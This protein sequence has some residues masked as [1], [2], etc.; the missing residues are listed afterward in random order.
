MAVLIVNDT[1]DVNA[2]G[3]S[4]SLAEPS[5]LA[6]GDLLLAM[7]FNAGVT[8]S[9]A[10]PGNITG[11]ASDFDELSATDGYGVRITHR[12]A[13]G[14]EG[15]TYA[16]TVSGDTVYSG[17][18]MLRVIGADPSA[19]VAAA[20]ANYGSGTT[21]TLPS[22]AATDGPVLAVANVAAASPIT[23]TPSGW[24]QYALYDSNTT[25]I[26]YRFIGDG[27]SS[28]TGTCTLTSSAP[29]VAQVALV[30]PNLTYPPVG[31]VVTEIG[32]SLGSNN[33]QPTFA[34][35]QHAGASGDLCLYLVGHDNPGA[36][37]ITASPGWT[38]LDLTVQ[39]S[40]V[41]KAA[42]VARVL[43]GA[44]GTGN[45]TCSIS[46]TTQDYAVIGVVIP[47]GMH[48]VT[49]VST[50]ITRGTPSTAGSGNTDPP[51]VT[52]TSGDYTV[53]TGC[54]ADA[55][56]G[57]SIT[58]IPSDYGFLLSTKSANSTSSVMVGLAARNV[59]GT[60]EN[61]GAWAHNSQENI[62]FTFAVPA[63]APPVDPPDAPTEVQPEDAFGY[64]STVV[65]NWTAPVDDGGATITGY[66]IR[67]S[68]DDGASWSTH[69]A[70]TGDDDETFT[71][72]TGLTDG[73]RYLFEVAAINSEGVGATAVSEW[74]CTPIAATAA[75][76]PP[77]VSPVS[78]SFDHLDRHDKRALV[79]MDGEVTRNWT[80]DGVVIYYLDSGIRDTHEQFTGRVDGVSLV[81]GEAWDDDAAPHGTLIASVGSGNTLGIASEAQTHM[82]KV[83]HEFDLDG[84]AWLEWAIDGLQWIVDNHETEYPGQ[85]AVVEYSSAWGIDLTGGGIV[86]ERAA[87]AALIADLADMGIPFIQI[88]HNSDFPVDEVLHL[89]P[90]PG[91][92][93]VGGLDDDD[94]VF[95]QT[96]LTGL[97]IDIW[98]QA[99]TIDH[100]SASSDTGY[101]SA[102]EGT[103]FAGPLV[104]G[105]AAL[106]L[107]ANPTLTARQVCDVL[108]ASSTK[109]TIVSPPSGHYD[110]I[111]YT[112]PDVPPADVSV[113]VT[114][115]T[116]AA[117]AG[118][119]TPTVSLGVSI[120]ASVVAAVCSVLSP[121]VTASTPATS[122]P[123]T[124]QAVSN[125]PPPA[126]TATSSASATPSTVTAPATVQAP[127]VA[128]GTGQTVT[129]DV[130]AVAANV[131]SPTVSATSSTTAIPA[132]VTAT[133]TVPAPTIT[134]TSSA[135]ATPATVVTASTAVPAPSISAGG[136]ATATPATV[137]VTATVPA[138]TVSAAVSATAT[139]S[140]ITAA[141]TVPA[142]SVS[143]GAGAAVT[144][145]VVT[146][147][148]SV[149][150]PT[151]DTAVNATAVPATIAASC[152]V[153]TPTVTAAVS[154]TAPALTVTATATVPTPAIST[155]VPTITGRLTTSDSTPARTTA[156]ASND[157]TTTEVFG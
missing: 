26:Y 117:T 35:P 1:E 65:L 101:G 130:V 14:T 79:D 19:P 22:V 73:T 107:E 34:A 123:S 6:S 108:L 74:G 23:S 139:A 90:Q 29:W 142:P 52:L 115:T 155:G 135:T 94:T 147:T 156:D 17:A 150:A 143:A 2:S 24:T 63:A 59:T 99:D 86:D 9:P 67:T 104:A 50:D 138:P 124:V 145:A 121:T 129:P 84:G 44:H 25:A 13:D 134:A 128:G 28:G 42:V 77:S 105:A 116:V 64:S 89:A 91:M 66:R 70:D 40:N 30:S 144:V 21:V 3:G 146:V 16:S 127:I 31:G 92:L 125:I 96:L 100:A 112:H 53:F 153:P 113:T 36:T 80:G 43:D 47:A 137:T 152:S 61:P 18:K 157:R 60:S 149:P 148:V 58:A 136:S 12:I 32:T 119:S 10:I 106:V 82:V 75:Q 49:T 102:G 27:E 122:T 88:A 76:T 95:P 114:P 62:G 37:A 54:V 97:T 38:V 56:T 81:P 131:P 103:S 132:T 133:S 33:A 55:T 78:T 71:I 109:N 151:I 118:V 154:A 4:I 20:D 141:V 98:A 11:F 45:N 7:M 69:T 120:A 85:R 51:S 126:V 68:T 83:W 46:G 93:M 8:S 15:P 72:T 110:R 39:G 57:N 5:S 140:T 48:S 41:I 87:A 111:L